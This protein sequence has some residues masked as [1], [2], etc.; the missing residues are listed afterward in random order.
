MYVCINSRGRIVFRGDELQC[1]L[2]QERSGCE[3]KI[4]CLED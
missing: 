3:L 2:V 4:I 1:Q